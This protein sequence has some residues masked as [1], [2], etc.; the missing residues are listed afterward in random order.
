MEELSRDAEITDV[1]GTA[2]PRSVSPHRPDRDPNRTRSPFNLTGISYTGISALDATAMAG[3]ALEHNL[4]A[5]PRISLSEDGA[6]HSILSAH[7]LTLCT[8]DGARTLFRDVSFT[9]GPAEHLLIVGTSGAGKS[10]LLRAVAGLWDRGSGTIQRPPSPEVRSRPCVNTNLSPRPW[11]TKGLRATSPHRG[12]TQRCDDAFILHSTFIRQVL[13][14]PQ[15][16][17]CTL[18]TLRQQLLYPRT[19]KACAEV[20]DMQLFAALRAV[21]LAG[22]AEA[23]LG[24]ERDWADELSLGEQQRLGFA[25]LLLSRPRL[26]LLDEATSALDL[27]SEA[28]MYGA[29]AAVEG[30]TFVSVG[31]RPSLAAHHTRRLRLFSAD[32]DGAAQEGGDG[33]SS[34]ELETI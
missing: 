13:F 17:Y 29:L 18:G 24:V 33:V 25:R 32:G 9:V 5:A 16:P 12:S 22:L 4:P 7:S 15:R 34:F 1:K 11:A 27:A 19:L 23:G 6:S 14:L 20:D 30:L 26:C 8:P 2:S 3:P 10:S 31:H 21:R 28:A